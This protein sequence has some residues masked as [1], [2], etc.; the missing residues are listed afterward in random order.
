MSRGTIGAFEA[1]QV[2]IRLTPPQIPYIP[3]GNA[4]L[5]V[6]TVTQKCL[7]LNI[8]PLTDTK[9]RKLQQTYDTVKEIATICF[10]TEAKSR[11]QLHRNL[12]PILTKKYPISAQLI[13]EAL[14]YGWNAKKTA[15]QI[16]DV[17]VRFDQNIS[18]F[19]ETSRGNP[20]VTVRTNNERIGLPIRQDGA[21]H[22]FLAHV[23]DD[24]QVTSIF[25]KRNG[26]FLACLK[27]D[28]PNPPTRPNVLGVD[29]NAG[30]V[31]I[32]ILTPQRRILRQL[33]LAGDIEHAQ[34]RFTKRRAKLRSH[35]DG[36][37]QDDDHSK[38]AM[39]LKK[40]GKRQHDYVQTNMWLLSKQLCQLAREYDANIA[41]EHLRHLRKKKDQVNKKARKRI[42]RIPYGLLRLT[43]KHK[44]PQMG[45][46]VVEV[47]P[48]YTSQTCSKCGHR[49]KANRKRRLFLCQKCG[50]T[51]NADRNASVNIGLRAI[52]G[53]V[54][55]PQPKQLKD[56]NSQVGASFNRLD[57]QDE[58]HSW[59]HPEM[60]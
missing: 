41:I 27:K 18:S 48:A 31:A 11:L 1:I 20:V 13:L 26:S 59:S 5:F 6:G 39:A 44:G 2:V 40:L 25:M 60:S 28:M 19:R 14:F 37:D 22:R 32:S 9:Q 51:A 17:I 33:Y 35:R 36:H 53:C 46:K 54:T 4:T 45:V 49:A 47:P 23:A 3:L 7:S 8:L 24:W 42:N 16:K 12:Y 43:L 15:D 50:L 38:A 21:Y 57:R 55:V 58:A 56:Q 52:L 29:V 34:I 30:S 10:K